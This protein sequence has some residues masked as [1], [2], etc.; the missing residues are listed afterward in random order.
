MDIFF[1]ILIHNFKNVFW[2]T[3]YLILPRSFLAST[4]EI[5]I[6]TNVFLNIVVC[7]SRAAV[8][9]LNFQ[10][11]STFTVQQGWRGQ[12]LGWIYFY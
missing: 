11:G 6:W 1:E 3:S 4:S 12:T 9:Y 7:K 2:Q 8:V 5:S 10:A